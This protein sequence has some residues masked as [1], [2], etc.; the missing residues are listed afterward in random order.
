MSF[1]VPCRWL[2]QP[3]RPGFALALLFAPVL[4]PAAPAVTPDGAMWNASATEAD[5][6]VPLE[7]LR[8]FYKL[9]PLSGQKPG[10][11]AAGNGELSLVFGPDPRDVQLGGICCRLS[12]PVRQDAARGLLVSETDAVKLIDPVLRPTYVANRRLV[13]TVVLDPAHGGHDTGTVTPYAR[14]AD[15]ALVV[16]TML[17]QELTK[18][19]YHVVLTRRENRYLSDQQR[20]DAANGALNP[21]L[22]SLHLNSGRSDVSGA[23]TYTMTPAGPG[24]SPLPGNEFDAANAALAVALQ[25]ALVRGAGARDGGCRRARYSLL[26]SLRCPAAMVELGYATHAEEGARLSSD[27]YQRQLALALADGIERFAAVMNPE[28]CLRAAEKPAAEPPPAPAKVE[29]AKP[30]AAPRK[31]TRKPATKTTVKAASKKTPAKTSPSATP[32]RSTKPS[33]TKKSSR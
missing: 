11:T 5:G 31:S 26:S 20:V 21:L 13:K 4:V 9:L 2:G 6:Y 32:K 1:L 29:P 25:S 23:E 28:T 14:E 8:S 22:V 16:A 3:G 7:E 17:Q 30:S 12:R 27:E 19:G 18:R 15:V 33:A 10:V 24:E